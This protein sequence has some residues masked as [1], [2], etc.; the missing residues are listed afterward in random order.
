MDLLILD[1]DLKS[2][3]MIDSFQS[4]IWTERYWS[5][6][7]FELIVVA[8]DMNLLLLQLNYYIWVRESEY[9]MIIEELT[10]NTDSEEGNT[11]T[12][13]GRSLESILERRIIWNQ[14]RVQGNFQN[15]IKK[16]LDLN[17]ISPEDE[18]RKVANLSFKVNSDP[19]FTELTIDK[20]WTGDNLYEAI[21]GI[22]EEKRVGFKITLEGTR[23]IFMLYIG[24]DRSY[25]QKKNPYVV[26]SPGF[27]N[28]INTEYY[29]TEISNKTLTLVAG[30]DWG[31]ERRRIVVMKPGGGLSGL[32]RKE[33][34][35]DA[36]DIQAK[37]D[38]GSYMTNE[39]YNELLGIRGYEKLS[40]CYED[41]IFDG[42]VDP[43]AMFQYGRDYFMG[44]LVQVMN[45]FKIESRTRI[46]EF[47][48]SY[49]EEGIKNYPTFIIEDDQW[50]NDPMVT[51]A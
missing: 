21:Q 40:E 17:I 8:D 2:V 1:E 27:G 5:C 20:Q 31:D 48:R 10:I 19:R 43:Y 4:L 22:C 25:E 35:T 51:N 3:G 24:T 14:T 33:L 18:D 16:I 50:T 7:D 6:G 34:Y 37:K 12:V 38:D 32:H 15:G 29:E 41:Y 9:V 30:E 23:F 46:T 28:L 26:F 36:R 42:E 13:K 11:I 47:I 39:E 45:E 44:D 49:N